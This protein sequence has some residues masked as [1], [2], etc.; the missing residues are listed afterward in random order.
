LNIKATGILLAGGKSRRMGT[1][2]GLV[3][4]NEKPLYSYALSVLEHCCSEILIAGSSGKLYN[5]SYQVVMDVY[6]EQGPAAGIHAA[7]QAATNQI[8]IVLSVDLPFVDPILLN[9]MLNNLGDSMAVA[10]VHA[11]GKVEPLCAVYHKSC[12]PAFEK[13]LTLDHNKIL[14]ILNSVNFKQLHLFNEN[15]NVLNKAFTNINTPED[16]A[17]AQTFFKVNAKKT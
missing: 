9:H 17:Q 12:I 8:C 16:L 4:L 15:E 6:A 13:A 10:P 11:D 5:T 3:L 7:L 14:D 2:K 1:D